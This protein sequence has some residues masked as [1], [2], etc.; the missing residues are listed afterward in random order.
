MKTESFKD[1]LS[2]T[3]YGIDD[4]NPKYIGIERLEKVRIY[5]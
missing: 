1:I 2:E 3:D 4:N 5:I